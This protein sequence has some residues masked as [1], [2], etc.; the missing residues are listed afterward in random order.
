MK[1]YFG[2]TLYIMYMHHI[3]DVQ[4]TLA[5]AHDDV[6]DIHT[7]QIQMTMLQFL[8]QF[9]VIHIYTYGLTATRQT[10]GY[11]AKERHYVGTHM[12]Y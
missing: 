5:V 6:L 10:E 3:L 2:N 7:Y 1:A 8:R 9:D 4:S 11:G 12:Y